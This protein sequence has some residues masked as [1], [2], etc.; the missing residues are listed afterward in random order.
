MPVDGSRLAAETSE[1]VERPEQLIDQLL[2]ARRGL[3]RE[4][5]C[6]AWDRHGTPSRRL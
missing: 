3:E 5:R 6:L 4:D 1:R 2:V